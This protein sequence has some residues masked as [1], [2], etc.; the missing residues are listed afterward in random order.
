M[1]KLILFLIPFAVI[2]CSKDLGVGG[3]SSISGT[4]MV[5]DIVVGNP[6]DTTYAAGEDVFL[7][8][9]TDTIKPY[10][11]SFET[12]W[13]GTYKFEYLRKGTYTVFVYSD[14]YPNSNENVPIFST[15]EVVK[16]GTDYTLDDIVIY[17]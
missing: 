9:G 5:V 1:K 10:D 8:Y 2:A 12:S 17:K 15:I 11:D 7:L 4:V 14:D 3:S 13:N 16:N 6:V